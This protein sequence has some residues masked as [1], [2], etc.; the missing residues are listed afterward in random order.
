MLKEMCSKKLLNWL[1]GR[2]LNQ[3]NN[4]KKAGQIIQSKTRKQKV[5]LITL[6]KLEKPRRQLKLQFIADNGRELFNCYKISQQKQQGPIIRKQL[7]IMR[8]LD[9]MILQRSI[10]SNLIPLQRPS[11]CMLKHRNGIKLY[12]WLERPCLRRRLFNYI[13]NKERSLNN[14]ISLRRLKSYI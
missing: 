12:K 7:N 11:K 9:N 5:P 1:R 8:M 4:W 13:L 6:W 14:K 2:I 10:I 3:L